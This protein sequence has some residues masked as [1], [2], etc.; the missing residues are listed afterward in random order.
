MAEK[1]RNIGAPVRIRLLKPSWATG[2]SFDLV[3]TRFTLERPL[4]RI[5]QSTHPDRFV[6]KGAMLMISGLDETTSRGGKSRGCLSAESQ[7]R[8]D[9]AF[10][11]S[12]VVPR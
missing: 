2:R 8:P 11:L 3:L 12:P 5:S 9:H 1:L 6:L 10:C 4:F 7:S